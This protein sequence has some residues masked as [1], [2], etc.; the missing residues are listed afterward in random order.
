MMT[1]DL[2][3]DDYRADREQES[4]HIYGVIKNK[5]SQFEEKTNLQKA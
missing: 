5:G 1:N 3:D 2:F 4:H